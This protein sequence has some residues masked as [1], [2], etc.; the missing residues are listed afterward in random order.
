M[1]KHGEH[2]QGIRRHAPTIILAVVFLLGVCLLAYPTVSDWWNQHHA[3]R[4]VASYERAVEDLSAEDLEVALSAARAYNA[5]LAE[6]PASFELADAE[7]GRYEGLL[8]VAGADAMATLEIPR[9]NV[10][11]PIYHG[12]S[13]GVLQAGVGHLM[14]SSLPVGGSS[15]HCVLMGHRGLPSARLLTDLDQLE[16][17]DSFSVTALG[18]KLWYE[19]DQI[20][21]VEPD[22]VS[23]LA[24][25][26]GEDLCTLV[27]CTPY[28]VNTHRLLVRGHRVSS[29]YEGAHLTSDAVRVDPLLVASVVAVPVLLVLVVAVLVSTRRRGRRA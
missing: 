23:S 17:G 16:V 12:T 7:L 11:L 28:G 8:A 14:G 3:T 10:K 18:D 24:I 19:V 13:D 15:T 27:T 29:P 21:I 26:P 1:A 4:A 5:E 9:I 2:T 22:D 20:L 6:T 25:V